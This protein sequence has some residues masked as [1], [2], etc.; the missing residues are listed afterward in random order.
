MYCSLPGSFVHRSFRQE[1]CSWLPFLSPGDLPEPGI[2]PTSPALQA[3]SLLTEPPGEK[4]KYISLKFFFQKKLKYMFLKICVET[5]PSQS[6]K[7]GKNGAAFSL[8]T[9]KLGVW[10]GVGSW[11]LLEASA[12]RLLSYFSPVQL[13]CDPMDCS[14]SGSSVHGILQA[15]ILEWIAIS[16]SRVSSQHRDQTHISSFTCL[17]HWQ[18]R[19]LPLVPLWKRHQRTKSYK[20]LSA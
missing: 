17:L 20:V 13:F 1:Y 15:R 8:R 11:E 10:R 7:L 19:S 6:D 14:P 4:P 3:D 12:S 5:S 9:I 2:E 18:V 16:S